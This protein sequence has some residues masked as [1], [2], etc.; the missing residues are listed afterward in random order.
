MIDLSRVNDIVHFKRYQKDL[1]PHETYSFLAATDDF[2][3][4]MGKDINVWLEDIKLNYWKN[5]EAAIK[6]K[7]RM[8]FIFSTT[9]TKIAVEYY[10]KYMDWKDVSE[11][12][13]LDMIESNKSN[14]IKFFNLFVS[15]MD[16]ELL[17]TNI[18]TFEESYKVIYSAKV[19][20]SLNY[21]SSP[22]NT[23]KIMIEG[24]FE[25]SNIY[26]FKFFEKH[27]KYKGYIFMDNWNID[28]IKH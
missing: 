20:N 28:N 24:I 9:A 21:I 10:R 1:K 16:S 19:S 11:G 8:D 22:D 25:T 27:E 3:P 6:A 5:N 7:T 12:K 14:S 18:N 4:K 15:I 13:I 17:F 26:L 2:M 23:E